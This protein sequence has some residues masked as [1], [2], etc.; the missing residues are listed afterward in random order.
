MKASPCNLILNLKARFGKL[1][2]SDKLKLELEHA[3]FEFETNA[4]AR[5]DDGP[6]EEEY[7]QIKGLLEQHTRALT[8]EQAER[9]LSLTNVAPVAEVDPQIHVD[10]VLEDFGYWASHKGYKRSGEFSPNYTLYVRHEI[11]E[12]AHLVRAFNPETNM[13]DSNVRTLETDSAP[14]QNT[15]PGKQFL[16]P[17]MALYEGNPMREI[18]GMSIFSTPDGNRRTVSVM[19]RPSTGTPLGVT[20]EDAASTELE[21]VITNH[22]FDAYYYRT[23]VQM[24][25]ELVADNAIGLVGLLPEFYNQVM[26]SSLGMDFTTGSG[27]NQPRGIVTAAPNSGDYQYS[28]AASDKA[29]DADLTARSIG[30]F[31]RI[32]PRQYRGSAVIMMH[33]DTWNGIEF[34]SYLLSQAAS[35]GTRTPAPTNPVNLL[36]IDKITDRA[37]MMLNGFPVYLNNWMSAWE[38]ADSAGNDNDKLIVMFVPSYYYQRDVQGIE[39]QYDPYTGRTNN[40]DLMHIS[41]RADGD[42]AGPNN[43]ALT[44]LRQNT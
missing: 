16:A 2:S 5:G 3:K 38:G 42:W 25:R 1:K 20:A 21:P 33:Q 34:A 28:I 35:N 37:P 24:T 14:G 23:R 9:S 18:P 13:V 17:R 8:I 15:I 27:T 6:S 26:Q 44:V 36:A 32:M 39:F 4:A 29:G 41:M 22:D 30:N 12:S 7:Q 31:L 40:R 11:P 10:Q 19:T 43:G